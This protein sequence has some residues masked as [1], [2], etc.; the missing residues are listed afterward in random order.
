MNK[1]ASNQS[2]GDIDMS[3]IWMEGEHS[4]FLGAQAQIVEDSREIASAWAAKHI[5]PNPA[6]KWVVGRFV[7]ADKANNNRQLFSLDGLQMARPTIAHAPMNMNHSPNRIVGSYIAAEMIY[8]TSQASAFNTHVDEAGI[9]SLPECPACHTAMRLTKSDA[10][11]PDCEPV[12]EQTYNATLEKLEQAGVQLNPFIEALGVF[13]RHYFPDEYR[14]VEAAHAEG[15]LF[16]S[17]ECVAEQVQ[18]TGDGG[19]GE[20]F[21]YAGRVSPTYCE[22]LNHAASDKFLIEPHFT[23]GA[24]LVPP[25]MPGWSHADIHSLVAQQMEAAERVYQ[26][27]SEELPHLHESQWE[28]L[29]HQLLLMAK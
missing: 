21:D 11:C 2:G 7:E 10:W 1:N 29:M 5:V 19:C 12:K 18:C 3:T 4:F 27:L 16:Y 24:I 6:Y 26:G 22:H 9:S 13:W 23:A 8:P 14:L 20:T 28:G 17:M 25:V 15:R